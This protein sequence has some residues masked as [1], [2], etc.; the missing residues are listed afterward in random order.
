MQRLRCRPRRRRSAAARAPKPLSD[1]LTGSAKIDYDA[2][3]LLFSDGDMAGALV[4]FKSA[5]D[6]S[7]DARL[8]WNIAACEKSL[9]HYARVLSYLDGAT[10]PKAARSSPRAI[11]KTPTRSSRTSAPSWATLA[12]SP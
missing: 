1:T 6:T 10:R 9:H 2:G 12:V 7:K 3:K 11:A 5:Y 8:L 4:K